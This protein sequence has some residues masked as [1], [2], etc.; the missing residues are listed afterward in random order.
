[1]SALFDDTSLVFI[2]LG[3]KGF[4]LGCIYFHG[5]QKLE[6]GLFLIEEGDDEP[7][8]FFILGDEVVKGRQH[9]YAFGVYTCHI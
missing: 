5:L 9:H 6:D 7:W 4:V 3:D 1:M 2:G 8:I